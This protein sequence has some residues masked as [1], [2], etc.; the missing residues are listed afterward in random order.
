MLIPFA[1]DF[2][3]GP[4]ERATTNH[5]LACFPLARSR[6]RFSGGESQASPLDD[7]SLRPAGR[8]E[9]TATY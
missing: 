5:R 4:Q 1:T 2:T 3:D 7:A 9:E 8:T 6:P